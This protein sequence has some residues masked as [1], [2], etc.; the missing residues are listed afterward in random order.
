[1]A[2]RGENHPYPRT[3]KVGIAAVKIYRIKA[4]SNASG[5]GYQLY[6]RD[7]EGIVKKPTFADPMEA[8][9]EARLQ[10][11][12]FASGEAEAAGMSKSDRNELQVARELLKGT[13]LLSAVKEWAEATAL[14]KGQLLSAAR[15]WAASNTFKF[16]PITVDDCV[17]RFIA[18]K[19]AKGKQGERTYRTKLKPA[20][21]HF[22]GRELHT[23][24]PLEWSAYLDRYTDGRTHNDY[25]KR[26]VTM[27][28]WAR[29]VGEHLPKNERPAVCSVELK[30]EDRAKVGITEPE[31]FGRLLQHLKVHHPHHLAALVLA[32]F[33]GM[34]GDE[35]HG[36]RANMMK[37]QIWEDINLNPG[38]QGE[39]EQTPYVEVTVAKKN[40]PAWRHVPLCPAAIQ[41]LALCPLPRQGNI[42]QAQAITRIRD[43]GR[44]AGLELP[45]NCFRHSYL[46]YQI[47]ITGDKAQVATWSG[48][49][50]QIVDQ[51]YRRPVQQ[52]VALEW[53][54]MTPDKAKKLPP[55][56][57]ETRGRGGLRV[58]KTNRM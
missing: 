36:K 43:I 37:R 15:A 53:F 34:R 58:S 2:S 8:E 29:D 22:R 28:F 51:R 46:S 44:T 42:C 54:S 50:V 19:E 32:G 20:A 52:A 35:I 26:A 9:E 48:N 40:T 5:W 57:A 27:C 17:D 18:A 21:D 56:Q 7:A 30:E 4:P 24:S 16:T 33:C 14:T 49:S 41:W 45:E 39:F 3:I 12:K 6:Y 55:L 1:M 23:V 38:K 13:P 47:A 10:A 11:T 31:S 25:K